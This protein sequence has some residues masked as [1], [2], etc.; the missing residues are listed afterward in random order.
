MVWEKKK[1]LAQ[2]HKNP[3]NINLYEIDKDNL[4]DR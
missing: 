1:E 2:V 3:K 4:K